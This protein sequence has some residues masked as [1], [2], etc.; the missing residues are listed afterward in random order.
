MLNKDFLNLQGRKY[1]LTSVSTSSCVSHTGIWINIYL[2]LYFNSS[3]SYN[4]FV[5]PNVNHVSKENI[6]QFQPIYHTDGWL[7]DTFTACSRS[8]TFF[9][10]L[11][12]FRLNFMGMKKRDVA[13]LLLIHII[14]CCSF[15][16][17][18]S[19]VGQCEYLCIYILTKEG[20]PEWAI[21]LNCVFV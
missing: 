15:P 20:G 13:S 10:V 21:R 18:E 14:L 9:Y 12:E 7:D 4:S 3:T 2:V 11:L 6:G 8:F 5:N 16:D 1:F 17:M 19:K